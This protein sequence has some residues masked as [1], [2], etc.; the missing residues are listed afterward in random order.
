MLN[1][2]HLTLFKPKKWKKARIF[3]TVSKQNFQLCSIIL[4]S[5]TMEPCVVWEFPSPPI[6]DLDCRDVI[7]Q[8]PC[9]VGAQSTGNYAN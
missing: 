5:T 6:G 7:I 3:T 2:K 4:H 1:V 8:K 9:I